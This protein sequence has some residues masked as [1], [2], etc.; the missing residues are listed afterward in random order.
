MG[1]EPGL[2]ESPAHALNAYNFQTVKYNY[3]LLL[4]FIRQKENTIKDLQ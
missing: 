3:L 4:L 1:L 2:F